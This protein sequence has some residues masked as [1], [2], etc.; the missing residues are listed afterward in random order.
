MLRGIDAAFEKWRSRRSKIQQVNSLA[1]CA[2][3]VMLEAQHM[4]ETG[5]PTS[6]R[7][8][9]APFSAEE[10]RAYLERNAATLRARGFGDAA[11]ALDGLAAEAGQ[12]LEDLESLEQRLAALEE[13]LVAGLKAAQSDDDLFA[14]RQELDRQLRPYRGKMTAEQ[15]SMLERQYFDRRLLEHADLPRLSLFYFQ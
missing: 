2:Q 8:S 10:L 11:A 1:Y 5:Q 14:A 15:I 12:H 7:P 3:A 13:K 6:R 9:Q 4:A